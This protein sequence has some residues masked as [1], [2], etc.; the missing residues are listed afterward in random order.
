VIGATILYKGA[1]TLVFGS[2]LGNPVEIVRVS[3]LML[4]DGRNIFG[5]A[6]ASLLKFAGGEATSLIV[7]AVTL[8][9]WIVVPLALAHLFFRR[10]DI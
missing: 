2:L 3:C 10:Q 6:G 5:A 8:G 1:K 7:L 9:F 4:L